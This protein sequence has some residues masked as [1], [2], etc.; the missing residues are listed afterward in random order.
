ME[1]DIVGGYAEL[2]VVGVSVWAVMSNENRVV[3]R[4]ARVHQELGVSPRSSYFHYLRSS[5]TNCQP[6]DSCIQRSTQIFSVRGMKGKD[7]IRTRR[8][9]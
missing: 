4:M 3:E 6:A 7:R 2:S 1:N 5:E 8:T 9:S